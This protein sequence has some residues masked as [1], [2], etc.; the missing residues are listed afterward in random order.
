LLLLEWAYQ[1]ALQKK[2]ILAA[3]HEWNSVRKPCG[4]LAQIPHGFR[5]M[6]NQR[7]HFCSF[8]FVTACL[9][10][11][12]LLSRKR[13]WY[14]HVRALLTSMIAWLRGQRWKLQRW[15]WLPCANYTPTPMSQ[16]RWAPLLMETEIADTPLVVVFGLRKQSFRGRSLLTRLVRS[17]LVKDRTTLLFCGGKRSTLDR[18]TGTFI[19]ND[20]GLAVPVV[21]LTSP[22][23]CCVLRISNVA[24]VLLQY[25]ARLADPPCCN[26][27]NSYRTT[28]N[29]A[30]IH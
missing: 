7:S 29:R 4:Y 3:S 18:S 9:V 24:K 10:V 30:I 26:L 28:W 8:G 14:R 1:L 12:A 6:H 2:D 5:A 17:E 19:R 11:E 27:S 21:N 25:C 15:A 13:A 23:R 22:S 20:F 16:H